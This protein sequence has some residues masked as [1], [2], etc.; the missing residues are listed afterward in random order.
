MPA[1]TFVLI[2][3]S[4]FQALTPTASSP[5]QDGAEEIL[6]NLAVQRQL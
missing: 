6:T 4:H 2:A 1:V 5:A 3:Y